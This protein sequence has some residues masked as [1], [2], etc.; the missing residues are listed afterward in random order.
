MTTADRSATGASATADGTA[1]SLT[2]I[3]KSFDGQ[4][5]L[6][7]ASLE[8]RWG[9]VHALLGENG[10]GKSTMMNIVCGLYS[11]DGGEMRVDGQPTT[12]NS[13]AHA[14]ACGIGMVHQ[15]FKLV[16]TFTVAENVLLSCAG[17]LGVSKP[18]AVVAAVNKA[19]ADL[20]FAIDPHARAVDLSIAERQ[21]IEILKLVLL[22][23]RIL[24]LDEPTAVLTDAEAE[25]VMSLL[26]TMA[27]KGHAVVLITHRLREVA[28]HADRATIM[29]AGKTV[30]AG[31]DESM[32]ESQLAVAMVGEGVDTDNAVSIAPVPTTTDIRLEVADVSY[33][34]TDGSVAIDGVSFNALAGEIVGIA[35]V[36][37]NGQTELAE[38]MYG[39]LPTRAGYIRTNSANLSEES[40]SVRRQSGLRL[41]PADRFSYALIGD[42]R[43]YENLA[44]TGVPVGQFG[45]PAWL[46]RRAMRK[47]ATEK[48]ATSDITGGKPAGRSRLLS[49]GNAQKLLLARELDE[50]A[51]VIIAHSP[52][53]GLDVR[54]FHAVHNAII[55]RVERGATCILISEDLDEILRLSTR[56]GVLSR[57]RLAGPFPRDEIDRGRIGA[58]MTGH[59]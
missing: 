30:L 21:R 46:D 8:V 23:A 57:G 55:A 34:R 43:A 3:Q 16:E 24:I 51:T 47:N 39:L 32:D 42:L 4:P 45:S 58:L 28:G 38:C 14:M 36:G 35:G 41:I 49:G 13:P 7:G 33:T 5:A 59:A 25:S 19:A 56:I 29:R 12:I 20:G 53:R 37:G 52:T 2:N 54:A 6:S 50:Q 15:H 44:L 10:A 31:I 48:F 26:A 22:G 1:L 40:I 27:R 9:E 17:K 11:A 18:G